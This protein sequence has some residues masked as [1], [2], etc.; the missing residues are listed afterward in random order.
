MAN[1]CR[2]A[3]QLTSTHASKLNLV[4]FQISV[5]LLRELVV[6]NDSERELSHLQLRLESRMRTPHRAHEVC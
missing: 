4:D 2:Y 5:P 6:V 3:G 1:H